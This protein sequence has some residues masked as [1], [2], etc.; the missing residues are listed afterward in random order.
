MISANVSITGADCVQVG[1]EFTLN[2]AYQGN[3]TSKK[4]YK[5]GTLLPDALDS[6]F[7]DT[8]STVGNC[9]Y[10]VVVT[11]MLGDDLEYSYTVLALAT[12]DFKDFT[13][14][15][16]V[17]TKYNGLDTV[18]NVPEYID[19]TYSY[20]HIT[21]IGESAFSGNTT[22]TKV[23]LASS[24]DTIE[25]TAFMEQGAFYGCTALTEVVST[26]NALKYVG[27]FAFTNCSSLQK[28]Q[29][30][31]LRLVGDNAFINATNLDTVGS[32][33]G[34]TNLSKVENIGVYAF[35]GTDVQGNISLNAIKTIGA[36]AL[37]ASNIE[38]IYIPANCIITYVSREYPDGVA[39][40]N[41]SSEAIAYDNKIYTT[42]EKVLTYL[43]AIGHTSIR[44]F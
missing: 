37:C 21:A 12:D 28:L 22:I 19:A 17:L 18:V 26:N 30:N 32:E 39:I 23:V 7:T 36:S 20:G 6:G 29:T 5:N 31:E 2:F 10:K 25:S 33:E 13:V 16:G 8:I 14:V 35:V 27:S 1:E 38:C 4:L 9:E 3:F 40:E 42:N 34:K 15:D 44:L 24:I 41:V 43:N 11:D